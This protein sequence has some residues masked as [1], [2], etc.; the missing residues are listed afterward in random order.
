MQSEYPI[1]LRGG[2]SPSE[3]RVEIQ[4]NGVW[5]TV[6]DDG[7]NT[8]DATV[9]C[10]QLSYRTA[11]RA[12][13]NAEFGAGSSDQPIWMDNVACS[14]S[15]NALSDCSFGGWGDHN[16]GHSEDAGVVCAGNVHNNVHVCVVQ[17]FM[18]VVY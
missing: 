4:Y 17:V 3:G 15:E 14:G 9:V 13:S 2:S 18:H 16:C 11:T 6:C 7:W 8:N 12:S 5:G 1:R 10:R